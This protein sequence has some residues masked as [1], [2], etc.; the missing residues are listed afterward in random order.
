M[1]TLKSLLYIVIF[2]ISLSAFS[3]NSNTKDTKRKS[4]A[5]LSLILQPELNIEIPT[6]AIN[7][8]FKFGVN[9]YFTFQGNK[10]LPALLLEYKSYRRKTLRENLNEG[11]YFGIPL[12]I[13]ATVDNE[14]LFVFGFIYG[15]KSYF[16]KNNNFFFDGGAGVSV[17]SEKTLTNSTVALVIRLNLGIRLS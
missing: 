5:H 4:I 1:K 15:T 17:F 13:I 8:T 3:Q 12:N 16:G 9:T 11:G 6:K 10:F 7:Q 14:A 2:I